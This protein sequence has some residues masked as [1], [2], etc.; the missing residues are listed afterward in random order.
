MLGFQIHHSP[1]DLRVSIFDCSSH[2][3]KK[4]ILELIL[5]GKSGVNMNSDKL[6]KSLY[7]L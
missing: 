5:R 6:E 1:G 2:F 4:V 7:K 3:S